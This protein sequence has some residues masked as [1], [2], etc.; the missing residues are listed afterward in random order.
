MQNVSRGV[1][2]NSH[3]GTA[4]LL[5]VSSQTKSTWFEIIL[6]GISYEVNKLWFYLSSFLCE[7]IN[8]LIPN[9]TI[10]N[11]SVQDN[12]RLNVDTNYI[13]N[14]NWRNMFLTV[15]G[16]LKSLTAILSKYI[17]YKLCFISLVSFHIISPK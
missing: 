1:I 2:A 8:D 6:I 3:D 13:I 7:T 15:W 12:L 14:Y 17:L 4:K 5:R 10:C 16:K 11:H 9:N